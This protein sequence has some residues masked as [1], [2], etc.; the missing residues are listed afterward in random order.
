M[1]MARSLKNNQINQRVLVKPMIGIE[2]SSRY[3]SVA[4][5][6][7]HLIIV[8]TQMA[9]GVVEMTH[10]RDPKKKADVAAVKPVENLPADTII[11]QYQRFLTS[12]LQKTTKEIGDKASDKKFLHPW[13][14]HLN[15][16]RW[17]AI[18]AIHQQIHRKQA[19][20]VAKQLV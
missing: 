2:D 19:E 12:F 16:R 6:M 15:A 13:F 10:G 17:M 18:A 9:D 4:M 3:W 11:P 5:V 7:E 8:G 1:R 14:G 20:A